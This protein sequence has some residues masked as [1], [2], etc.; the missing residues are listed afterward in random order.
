MRPRSRNARPLLVLAFALALA[1]RT[2]QAQSPTASLSDEALPPSVHMRFDTIFRGVPRYVLTTSAQPLS[3]SDRYWQVLI[4]A[5]LQQRAVLD[6]SHLADGHLEAHLSAWGALDLAAPTADGHIAGDIAVAW[7]RY[8]RG[9][10]GVW[11]GR[12]FMPWGAP[13]GVH[14]DG[15]GAEVQLGAGM[16]LEAV[17]GRPVTPAYGALLGPHPGFDGVTAAGGVRFGWAHPGRASASVS[18][19]EHWAEGIP[20]RRVVEGSLVVTPVRWLDA[21]GSISF[22]LLGLGVMQADADAA[23]WIGREFEFDAGYGHLNPALMIP[24]W[25]ILSVFVTRTFD[26]GRAR[27]SWR[28][29]PNVAVGAE[30]ALQHYELPADAT[31]PDRAAVTQDSTRPDYI[32][33]WGSRVEVFVRVTTTDR[34]GQFMAMASH[35]DDGVRP[36]TLVRLAGSF[37][38]VQ[39]ILCAL[40]AATALD[41]DD[42]SAP[43]TSWY[44]R[45]SVD[46]PLTPRWR[47]GG[48]LDAV[49][50]PIAQGELRGMLHLTG[51]VDLQGAMPAG[52]RRP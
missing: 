6:A 51:F 13:G 10:W 47:L 24:R 5:P 52:G 12:R 16:V 39:D 48:S 49:R 38:V 50:S 14:I 28:I 41:N 26:E 43:R 32:N 34:R 4:L 31:R 22:D 30:G 29:T 44:G 2:A 21:R 15:A 7:A 1:A 45:V 8:H 27:A 3:E 37:P 40:E 25:S 36:M 9:P 33:P 23:A 46:G 18:Y 42:V 17:A 20:A 19:L 11:A 35:R